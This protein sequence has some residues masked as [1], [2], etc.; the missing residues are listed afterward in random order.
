MAN[1][2]LTHD[3][4]SASNSL[5]NVVCNL[6]SSADFKI[7]K[8]DDVQPAAKPYIKFVKLAAIQEQMINRTQ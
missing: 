3:N 8:L 1:S 7:R 5:R 4:C 2:E 6:V